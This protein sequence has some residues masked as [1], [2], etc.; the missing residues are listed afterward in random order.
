M[1]CPACQVELP[2]DSKYC[3]QC[4]A[5]VATAVGA[6]GDLAAALGGRYRVLRLLGRGGMGAVHLAREAALDRLVAIKTLPP[7]AAANPEARERFRREARTAARLAHPGIVPLFAYGEAGDTPYYVMGYVQGES[8]AARLARETQFPPDEVRELLAALADALDYAHRQGVVH[9]DVK[10]DNV[11]LNDETGRPLLADFGIAKA[12]GLTLT[13]TGAIVGTPHYMSPEQAAGRSGLDGRSDIYALGVMGFRMLSGKIPFDAGSVEQVLARRLTQDPPPLRSLAP[14]VPDDLAAAIDRCLAREP[15]AR[16]PDARSLRDALAPGRGLDVDL[17]PALQQVEAL[18]FWAVPVTLGP[19]AGFLALGR[20]FEG[21][22]AAWLIVVT[23]ASLILLGRVIGALRGGLGLAT[24]IRVALWPPAGWA[25]WYPSRLRRPG[26]VWPR[27]PG[28]VR[29]L[30]TFAT[31]AFAFLGAI[32]AVLVVGLWDIGGR[33]LPGLVGH[34]AGVLIV[35]VPFGFP[36]FALALVLER[37]RLLRWAQ[38]EGISRDDAHRLLLTEPTARS[39]FWSRPAV[40]QLLKTQVWEPPK[41]PH[42]CLNTIASAARQC[43]GALGELA[44][45][46]VAAARRLV[47][48]L[49]TAEADMAGLGPGGDDAL[50]RVEAEL[51][52]LGGSGALAPEQQRMRGL[53]AEQAEL[54]RTLGARREE[55][56][57]RRLALT[58]ALARLAVVLRQARSSDVGGTAPLRQNISDAHALLEHETRAAVAD[59]PTLPR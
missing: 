23:L 1:R 9:R 21:G 22:L 54:L 5:P 52:A 59:L 4:A 20:L 6:P 48:A 25:F 44:A 38:R 12:G 40:A 35:A 55:A 14:Q 8:L 47:A 41:D 49:D 34:V 11:L 57:D 50:A 46:A 32:H 45:E 51:A 27:L 19:L 42:A 28:P 56:L 17:P 15:A 29:R 36:V 13:G 7:D 33:G 58:R 37:A 26:D 10:P 31:G 53:L 24:T 18:G 2:A 43:T 30:R 16:W 3:F 39:G